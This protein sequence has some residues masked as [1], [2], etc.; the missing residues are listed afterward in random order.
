MGGSIDTKPHTPVVLLHSDVNGYNLW[1][2]TV[3][4]LRWR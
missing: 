4:G 2:S 3:E 1:V